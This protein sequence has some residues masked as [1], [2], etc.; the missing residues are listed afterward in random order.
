MVI[1]ID[2]NRYD[3]LVKIFNH[4]KIQPP[5][6]IDGIIEKDHAI[7]CKKSHILALE[8]A[9]EH[10]F[11]YCII[12]EDDAYPC[13]DCVNKFNDIIT[14]LNDSNIKWDVLVL[15]ICGEHS[16]YTN[17]IIFHNDDITYEQVLKSKNI[18]NINED[19]VQIKQYPHGSHAYIVK[20]SAYNE[21]LF[22][23]K[24]KQLPVDFQFGQNNFILS[25][26]LI[27]KKSLFIQR[28][29]YNGVYVQHV[30]QFYN[31]DEIQ[32]GPIDWATTRLP[33]GFD[34]R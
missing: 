23:M 9:K 12:F 5:M 27:T 24:H 8:Y 2:Q 11:P 3:R 22:N 31:I 1:S 16:N 28:F 29:D 33:K 17:N 26:V 25:K 14:R 4:F 10:K 34:K 13:I 20:K 7:A 32:I 21:L 18:V 30:P 6:K 19:T 15:G